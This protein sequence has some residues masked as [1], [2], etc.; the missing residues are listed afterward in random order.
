MNVQ[1]HHK[2]LSLP[3]SS[4]EGNGYE[5]RYINAKLQGCITGS[6][7]VNCSESV[8]Q[9]YLNN[10]GPFLIYGWVIDS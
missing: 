4:G 10:S 2:V 7:T 5:E 9:H 1:G 3:Y 8:A 6:W